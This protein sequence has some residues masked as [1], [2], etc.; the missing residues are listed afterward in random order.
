MF[1]RIFFINNYRIINQDFRLSVKKNYF[2]IGRTKI[3]IVLLVTSEIYFDNEK[4]V[5]AI[6]TI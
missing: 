1:D 6:I 3:Y 5:L 4:S 2:T